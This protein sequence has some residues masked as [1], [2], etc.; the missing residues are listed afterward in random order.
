MVMH[1]PVV[2]IVVRGR[3]T[4]YIRCGGGFEVVSG[5]FGAGLT[6]E[7]LLLGIW[8]AH[9]WAYTLFAI[10]GT[11]LYSPIPGH[12]IRNRSLPF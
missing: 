7:G 2:F 12:A 8:A 11:A 10:H 4:A 6:C 5:H 9:P 3:K 1:C